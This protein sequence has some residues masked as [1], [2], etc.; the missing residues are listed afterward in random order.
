MLLLL[1]YVGGFLALAGWLLP[2]EVKLNDR[3]AL[4]FFD[5]ESVFVPAKANYADI[6]D[7]RQQFEVTDLSPANTAPAATD[8]AQL[9]AANTTAA[10]SA[11]SLALRFAIQYP[12]GQD[13]LLFTFFRS[14]EQLAH[15]DTL[16]R[17]L[18]YGDSQIEGDRITSFLRNKMQEKFGGCGVGLVPLLDPLGNRSSLIIRSDSYW[19]KFAAYGAE[20]RKSSP[21]HYGIMGSYFRYSVT[22]P[23]PAADSLLAIRD[24]VAAKNT[25]T[26]TK[27]KPASIDLMPSPM[28]YSRDSRF[29]NIKILYGRNQKPFQLSISTA[30]GKEDKTLL[31]TAS[32]F[33]LY[34]YPVTDQFRKVHIAFEGKKSPELYGVALDCNAGVAIDN[35]PFR[36]SSG[37]EFTRMNRELLQKQFKELNVKCIILQF[38]VNVVPYV[39]ADYKFYER[40]FYNQLKL[41]KRLHPDV[42]ILVVGVSDMSRKEGELYASYPNIEKIRDAQRNAAFKAGCA[43][44][45]L[46]TA[47]GGKDSMPS[48]VNATPALANKDFTH[49]T[50]KG[51]KIVS[52]MMYKALMTEYEKFAKG[53]S[54]ER[55]LGAKNMG[56]KGK[57]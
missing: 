13:T 44:W 11:A 41:L 46:Y 54:D 55:L 20:Y 26:A 38:G 21:K 33:G 49:F 39:T 8:T 17:V 37:I 35:M 15:K 51:A 18:H 24:S 1:L 23:K 19:K 25:A 48:W 27:I 31:D 7:I 4:R 2:K 10:D 5:L 9:A 12:G 22:T 45:D 30:K 57:G 52:E 56:G 29:Q 16:I 47:M 3:F 53:K 28:A 50:P 34:S 42:S 43:F 6:S 40:Q 32:V 14:L 36:G